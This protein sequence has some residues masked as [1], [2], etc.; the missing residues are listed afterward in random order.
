MCLTLHRNDAILCIHFRKPVRKDFTGQRNPRFKRIKNLSPEVTYLTWKCGYWFDQKVPILI[1]SFTT[2][3]YFKQ[4]SSVSELYFNL[5]NIEVQ[6][7]L[8]VSNLIW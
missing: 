8:W 2:E 4:D 7:E 3:E 1:C 5:Q 6:T